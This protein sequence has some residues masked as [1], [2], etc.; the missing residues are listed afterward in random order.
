MNLKRLNPLI[1]EQDDTFGIAFDYSLQNVARQRVCDD[2]LSSGEGSENGQT[3][4]ESC[5][6]IDFHK[7]YGNLRDDQPNSVQELFTTG[8]GQPPSA[9]S[10]RY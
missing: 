4:K 7:R 1:S 8:L 10:I 9:E 3:V 6:S 2:C 5:F